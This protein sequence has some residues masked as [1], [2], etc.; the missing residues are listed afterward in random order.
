MAANVIDFVS[1]PT[2]TR[3]SLRSKR[4]AIFGSRGLTTARI[5][6]RYAVVQHAVVKAKW[7]RIQHIC[8][9]ESETRGNIRA[10]RF[11]QQLGSSR[12][13]VASRNV[14]ERFVAWWDAHVSF[15]HSGHA[16][17]ESR[18]AKSNLDQR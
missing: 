9:L 17:R 13:N 10:V 4:G 8:K 12:Q 11:C 15:G 14:V 18:C 1:G 5:S 3:P 6:F 7:F 2:K 16:V